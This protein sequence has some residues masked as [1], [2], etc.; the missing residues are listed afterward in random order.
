M[1]RYRTISCDH[2]GHMLLKRDEY[3]E[4]CSHMTRRAKALL[5]AKLVQVSIIL[6]VFV[7]MYFR[8]R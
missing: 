5:T 7:F 2:C 3:C 6:V 1:P 8:I 4:L